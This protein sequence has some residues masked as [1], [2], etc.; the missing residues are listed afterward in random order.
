M[1]FHSKMADLIKNGQWTQAIPTL[2]AHVTDNPDDETALSLYATALMRAGEK[3]A[4][5][6]VLCDTAR[7]FPQSAAAQADLGFLA[8]K[9]DNLALAVEGLQAATKLQPNFYQAWVFLAQAQFACGNMKEAL[10]AN[11]ACENTDPLGAE[12]PK[13]QKAI[14]KGDFARAEG[15]ARNML[16]RVNGHPR[17]AFALAYLASTVGAHEEQAQILEHSLAQYPANP[18]LYRSLS[19][20]YEAVGAYEKAI[21]VADMLVTLDPS[22]TSHWIRARVAGHV[23]D[24]NS[25][26]DHADKAIALLPGGSEE[27]GKLDLMRGHALKILGQRSESEEAYRAC[28]KNTPGNGAGWW[29]LADLKTFQFTPQDEADMQTLVDDETLD[30]AQRSQAAFALA[31]AFENRGDA[32]AAFAQYTVANNLRPDIDFDPG[33]NDQFITRLLASFDSQTLQQQ[34]KTVPTGPTPIFIVGMPRAGSTLIEQILASHSAIEGTMELNT[35][36]N[37]ERTIRIEGGRRFKCDYPESLQ[38]F[39]P[40]ALT[41]YGQQYLDN[42]AI[43]RT[44]KPYFIDK[45]P[46]NYERIGLIHKILPQAIIID[47][48]RDPM[49]CGYSAYRQHFA[50]GHEYSYNLGHIGAYYKGYLRVIDHFNEALPGKVLTV[51]YENMVQNTEATIRTILDHIGLPFEENCLRFFENKRPVRTASSEQV[52]QP[53]YTKGMGQWKAVEEELAPLKQALAS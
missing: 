17:G 4:S 2:A 16:A 9:A 7:R 13:M 48:R 39:S 44:G 46:P 31:K 20:A 22:V 42:S 12:F 5:L 8:M 43:F 24:F 23:G 34:A 45:L 25:A 3:D 37:L 28:I 32:K 30:A 10:T 47:A 53:I 15:T 35:L 26:L 1:S 27:R 50:A 40:D 51:Q 36:P 52:R 38:K 21:K 6:K 33:K 49:D 18:M 19:E 41:A 11:E 29:G 14:K